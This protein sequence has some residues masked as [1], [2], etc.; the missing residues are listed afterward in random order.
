MGREEFT[1]FQEGLGFIRGSHRILMHCLRCI[2]LG[3]I[4]IGS[5]I[6]A[7]GGGRWGMSSGGMQDESV[8]FG[9]PCKFINVLTENGL[10]FK[11]SDEVGES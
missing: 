7:R 5:D 10:A 6:G 8:G 9:L 2:G 3:S 1:C 11:M 4:I